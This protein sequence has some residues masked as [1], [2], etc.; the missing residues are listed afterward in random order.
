MAQTA[1]EWL[2]PTAASRARLRDAHCDVRHQGFFTTGSA[3]RKWGHLHWCRSVFRKERMQHYL[4]QYE[5]EHANMLG[6]TRKQ[7][8]N[9]RRKRRHHA[10]TDGTEKLDDIMF[11]TMINVRNMQLPVQVAIIDTR[12]TN[13]WHCHWTHWRKLWFCNNWAGKKTLPRYSMRYRTISWT[14]T[15][16]RCLVRIISAPK[17][18]RVRNLTLI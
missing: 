1:P 15:S 3:V 16:S 13:Q 12:R 6:T 5:L 4:K 9:W 18:D 11:S 14:S 10:R 17:I 8:L 2:A 7:K